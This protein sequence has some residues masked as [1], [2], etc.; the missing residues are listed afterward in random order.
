MDSHE[1]GLS[2]YN[3]KNDAYHILALCPDSLPLAFIY[4]SE[5]VSIN[6]ANACDGNLRRAFLHG[7][8]RPFPEMPFRGTN[9][10]TGLETAS[11]TGS[12]PFILSELD[13][14]SPLYQ[15]H[16]RKLPPECK[17]DGMRCHRKS[18]MRSANSCDYRPRPRRRLTWQWIPITS[19]N[20]KEAA[21]A[22]QVEKHVSYR[23]PFPRQI[24]AN[25]ACPPNRTEG[26]V[27]VFL[28]DDGSNELRFTFPTMAFSY[29]SGT[30]YHF[31]S[32][33]FSEASSNK[34]EALVQ[35]YLEWLEEVGPGE[36][37]ARITQTY[38]RRKSVTS[39]RRE[40]AKAQ[41][42]LDLSE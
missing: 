6:I 19:K 41:R 21:V 1:G 14:Y 16:R 42:A 3:P 33:S 38:L 28:R 18:T 30:P 7:M 26:T 11:H 25:P 39:R 12:K 24:R 8:G 36:D 4:L 23:M 20:F 2:V 27:G 31:D 9:I 15:L 5:Y 13:S 17:A 32:Q 22:A 34:C 29:H 37:R 35:L 40:E 10:Q